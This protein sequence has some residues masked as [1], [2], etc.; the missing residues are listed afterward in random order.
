MNE[1]ITQ[2]VY[3]SRSRVWFGEGRAYDHLPKRPRD[4]WIVL[5]ALSRQIPAGRVYTEKELN[6]LIREWLEGPGKTFFVDHV[7]LRRELVD[8][9]FLD[10]DPAGHGYAR[11]DR[12]RGRQEFELDAT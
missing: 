10:R 7:A 3:E 1:P 4:R 9:G 6:Q 5:H 8:A 11:S 12:Y 2:D